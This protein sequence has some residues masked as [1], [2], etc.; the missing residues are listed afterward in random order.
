MARYALVIGIGENRPPL[1]PL[2]KT[3]GDATAIAQVLRDHGG[4]HVELLE[5]FG[6]K[7][8]V[9]QGIF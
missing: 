4:F 8:H 5:L 3:V 6:N 2:T 9:G 7:I 1:R